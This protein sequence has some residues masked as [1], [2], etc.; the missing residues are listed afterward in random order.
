V[1]VNVTDIV[2]ARWIVLNVL[3]SGT[4]AKL[5]NSIWTVLIIGTGNLR[6]SLFLRQTLAAPRASN[7]S[8]RTNIVA[9]DISSAKIFIIAL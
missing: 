8:I 2:N 9:A 1:L 6:T 7:V 5:H 4:I 3:L